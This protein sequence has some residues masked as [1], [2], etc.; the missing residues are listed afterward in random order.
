M[1]DDNAGQG[2]DMDGPEDVDLTAGE[3]VEAG[4]ELAPECGAV[5]TDLVE[6][7]LGS[8]TGMSR[9]AVLAH[10]EGCPRCAA[11]V[12]QL[13]AAADQLLFLAPAA[14]P[15]VGFEAGV[16]ARLGLHPSVT[17]RR[18]WASGPAGWGG[19]WKL[20]GAAAIVLGAFAVGAWLGPS[21]RSSPGGYDASPS[22]PVG[23]ASGAVQVDALW[24]G[25]RNVGQVMVY[26]GNPTW[27]FMY[28]DDPSW[29]GTLR[30]EVSV[31]Q[32]RTL[33]LGHF[34]LSGGKGAW[35][36]STTQ[37]AGRLSRALVVGSS[38]AVLASAR[39]S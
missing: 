10:L 22:G 4:G 28:M 8:L 9:V 31:D 25:H 16:F 11:E 33:T 1:N 24:S 2:G 30:C 32:G 20:V 15:P 21:L 18:R 17:A 6:V 14:E 26:P 12:E 3:P 13:S 39:L 27:L 37:P 23:P 7:A 29:Q 34:W 19:R 35:A 36:A 5:A 38:G